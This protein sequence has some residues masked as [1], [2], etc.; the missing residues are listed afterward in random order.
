MPTPKIRVATAVLTAAVAALWLTPAIR[1][2]SAA[3]ASSPTARQADLPPRTWNSTRN[4]TQG[5]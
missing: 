3:T 2:P 4:L 5:V 1:M